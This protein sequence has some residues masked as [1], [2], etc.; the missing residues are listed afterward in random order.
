MLCHF[1]RRHNPFR[2]VLAFAGARAGLALALALA[3]IVATAQAPHSLPDAPEPQ[4]RPLQ[5]LAQSGPAQSMLPPTQDGYGLNASGMSPVDPQNESA[6]QDAPIVAMARHSENSRYWLSGQ[7]NI[8]FQGDLPFHSP[9][10]GTNSF[11]SRGEYKTSLLGTIYTALRPTH[12]IRYNNDLILDIES[13]GGRGLSEAF[14]L[15]GFTNLDVVRNPNL[16]P[17]PYLSHYEIHQVIGFTEETTSQD[18]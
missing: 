6:P 17:T 15:A 9:Y 5:Q 12:S 1:G 14:G 3:A 2:S 16:G 11:I 4:L 13:A 7:A 8:I 18:P 10:Q